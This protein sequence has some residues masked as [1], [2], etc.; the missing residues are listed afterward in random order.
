MSGHTHMGLPAGLRSLGPRLDLRCGRRSIAHLPLCGGAGDGRAGQGAAGTRP[1]SAG[2]RG[3]ALPALAAGPSVHSATQQTSQSPEIWTD[4][5]RARTAGRRRSAAPARASLRTPHLAT[6]DVRPASQA[7]CGLL[8]PLCGM[9]AVSWV[10]YRVECARA[11]GWDPRCSH[12][13]QRWCALAIQQMCHSFGLQTFTHQSAGTLF[14]RAYPC[15]RA[16]PGTSANS[17]WKGSTAGW[18]PPGTPLPAPW[19][20]LGRG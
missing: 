2:L 18:L 10:C 6:C 11:V 15:L 8:S 16:H 7:A 1:P 5:C 14:G 20:S 9:E 4:R 17:T 3:V 13:S 19:L 12:T